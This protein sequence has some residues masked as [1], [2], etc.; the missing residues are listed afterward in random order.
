M[1]WR[2]SA[3]LGG[4]MEENGQRT[5]FT[6]TFHYDYALNRLKE[7]WMVSA[8]DMEI[9]NYWFGAPGPDW[10][11]AKD[12]PEGA[13]RGHIYQVMKMG[14]R[15]LSCRDD[16]Y[17]GFSIVRPDA[18][19]KQWYND[20]ENLHYVAR[21]NM[22][23]E[24]MGGATGWADH[25]TYADSCGN[26]SLWVGLDSGLPVYTRGPTGC[27]SGDAGNSYLNH[28][29]VAPE[30]ALFQYNFSS[31]KPGSKAGLHKALWGSPAEALFRQMVV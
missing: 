16:T 31:C 18:F 30:D 24:D 29:L 20:A 4:W 23:E 21:E 11:D 7:H 19:I 1:P 14:G 17:P 2:W 25:W 26:F 28:T 8:M 22:S 10:E 5:N 9:I 3:E 15:V 12:L 6:G 27:N 13:N